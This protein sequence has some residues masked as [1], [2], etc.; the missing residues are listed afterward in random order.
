MV[1][2]TNWLRRYIG[3]IVAVIGCFLLIILTY[4][5]LGELF[6]DKY[7]E[8]VG[9]NITSISALAI[10]LVMIQIVIKQGIGEQALSAGLNTPDTTEKY[11][12]HKGLLKKLR[13]KI[14]FLPYFLSMR[15]RRE[16]QTKK[17]EFLV[18]NNFTSEKSLY[19]HTITG[20]TSK[21]SKFLF[22]INKKKLIKKYEAINI[23]MT[24]DSIKW[25]TTD[26][27]YQKNGRIEKLDDFRRKRI[28]KGLIYGMV[29]MFG[30]VFITG[31]LFLDT[32]DIPFIQKTIKFISYIIVIA[33]TALFDI[34][35][36]YEK[37][38]FVVPNELEEINNIWREFECWAVPKWVKAEVEAISSSYDHIIPLN[39]AQE[40][41]LQHIANPTEQTHDEPH[42]NTELDED[43]N[44]QTIIEEVLEDERKETA[45][46][47]ANIQAEPVQVQVIQ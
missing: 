46:S 32:A 47:G 28:A 10:G 4:G 25:A 26:V 34:S 42:G 27:V 8:N 21:F 35:K 3:A 15:N 6:T 43:T 18:A 9:G 24:G 7:W 11:T 14:K 33:I 39:S 5:D 12:E 30:T 20:K 17:R 37:G 31:G 16:T 22:N 38:A 36:N 23:N 45:A 2:V 29:F 40:P 1:N 44:N 19:N 41:P 13:D